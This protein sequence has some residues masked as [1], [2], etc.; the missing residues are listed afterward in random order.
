MKIDK[1]SII[2]FGFLSSL[3]LYIIYGQ[4]EWKI[5]TKKYAIAYVFKIHSVRGPGPRG[6][7]LFTINDEEYK[8]T[9]E[10]GNKKLHKFFIVEFIEGTPRMNRIVI[11]KPLKRHLLIPQ[12]SG[13]WQECPI[14][15]NGTIKKKFRVKK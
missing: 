8:G 13:G 6:D 14:N 2:I 12:P 10:N 9:V 7:Y 15:E 11:E 4:I 5:K 1:S 3:A